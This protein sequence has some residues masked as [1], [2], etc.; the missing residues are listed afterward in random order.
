MIEIVPAGPAHPLVMAAV[1]A[2][3]FAAGDAWGA[4]VIAAQLGQAGVVGFL[5][6]VGGMIL[7]RTVAEDAEVL[8]V[9]VAPDAQ[10]QGVG[11]ALL[12]SACAAAKGRGA[13]RLILEVAVGNVAARA[14]Y[15]AMGAVQIGARANYYADGSDALVLAIGLVA[16][17]LPVR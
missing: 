2:A 6:P 16:G 12:V 3:A 7:V 5:A 17:A 4:A 10:R 13:G 8:T 14:L 1:H 9:A 15:A 11:R